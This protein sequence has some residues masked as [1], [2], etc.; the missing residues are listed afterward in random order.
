MGGAIDF[1]NDRIAIAT[2]A[3]GNGDPVVYSNAGGTNLDEL[4]NGTTY[5]VKRVG[6]SSIELYT[7]YALSTKVN[8]T[9]SGTGSHTL[10]RLGIN[11]TTDQ[12][13]FVNH[14][15]SS[16]DPIRV[17]IGST[18]TSLPTGI[19]T[20][21]FYFVGSATTNSFTLHSTRS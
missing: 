13:T 3:F 1:T 12:I 17:A 21:A 7:T 20:D 19:T 10:T 8:F 16:G 5:Y 9:A 2:T 4:S 14:G 15:Y 6:I 18:G 11:T